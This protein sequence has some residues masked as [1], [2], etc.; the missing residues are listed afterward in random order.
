MLGLQCQTS[1]RSSPAVS[2]LYNYCIFL[3]PIGETFSPWQFCCHPEQVILGKHWQHL[4]QP[5][6]VCDYHGTFHLSTVSECHVSGCF[7]LPSEEASDKNPN[8]LMDIYSAT[9]KLKQIYGF[10]QKMQCFSHRIILTFRKDAMGI[11]PA[12]EWTISL[13]W[14][15]VLSGPTILFVLKI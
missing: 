10:I 14:T 15:R 11:T 2:S 9:T 4:T 8:I 1:P 5:V 7:Y 12:A 6:L 13:G 3:V